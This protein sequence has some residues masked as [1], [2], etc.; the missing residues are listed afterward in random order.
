M[1]SLIDWANPYLDPLR[2]QFIPLGSRLLLYA[3]GETGEVVGEAR[4][5]ELDPASG[6]VKAALL[7]GRAAP[8]LQVVAK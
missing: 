3:G 7:K 4:L 5:V 2:I 8:E 6:E 1:I